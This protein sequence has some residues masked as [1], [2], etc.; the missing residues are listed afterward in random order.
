[1]EFIGILFALF[2]AGII[3]AIFS[4]AFKNRGPWSSFWVFFI[5]LF[6]VA[7]GAGEWAAPRGPSAWGY[8]WIPGLIAAII[9]ALI[10]AAASPG[11]TLSSNGNVRNRRKDEGSDRPDESEES[12]VMTAML[13]IFFWILMVVLAMVAIIGM[14]MRVF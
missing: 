9:V 3:T 1:M 2:F 14:I 13:G 5:L 12:V 10:L 4:L 6:F 7:L 8:Y 11:N